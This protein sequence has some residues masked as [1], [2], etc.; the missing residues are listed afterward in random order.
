MVYMSIEDF[1]EKA[2]K[3]Q[4][5]TR[6]E[7]LDAA[8]HMKEGNPDARERLMESYLPMTA[9]HIKRAKAELQTLGL[10]IYCVNA[11]EKAVDSFDFFQ[12]SETFTHRLS[13]HLRN[14]TAKY[15]AD[16]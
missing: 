13:W 16:H 3:C 6:Q 10:A 1:F 11:L 7:E 5:L 9:Q 14:A 12:E 4:V 15:I 2:E 8:Q